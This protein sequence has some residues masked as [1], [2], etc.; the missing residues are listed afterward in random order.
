MH[1]YLSI[2]IIRAMK[3]LIDL[4]MDIKLVSETSYFINLVT[5]FPLEKN[6][7]NSVSV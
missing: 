6:L 2:T 1:I 7:L 3:Y 4:M 5:L